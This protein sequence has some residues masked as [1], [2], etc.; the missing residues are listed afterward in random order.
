MLDAACHSAAWMWPLAA[1]YLQQM[2]HAPRN[3]RLSPPRRGAWPRQSELGRRS[4]PACIRQDAP[5]HHRSPKCS[6]E[7]DLRFIPESF[8]QFRTDMGVVAPSSASGRLLRTLEPPGS[9]D[10]ARC[11]RGPS[12]VSASAPHGTFMVATAHAQTVP[13]ITQREMSAKRSNDYQ[14]RPKF[15]AD[16][17]GTRLFDAQGTEMLP[18]F[19]IAIT[20][21]EPS[22]VLAGLG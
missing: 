2:W 10:L 22:T 7:R 8:C 20:V 19:S 18:P 3:R 1:T 17:P 14:S 5:Q 15:S 13:R 16:H 11:S 4:P 6:L 9:K 12:G 21:N